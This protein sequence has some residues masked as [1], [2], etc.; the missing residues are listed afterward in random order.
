MKKIVNN[1]INIIFNINKLYVVMNF[2]PVKKYANA[3]L[4]KLQIIK[5]NKGKAGVYCWRNL[6][7]GK[8]Y[9]GC[10]VNLGKRF[11]EYYSIKY[12][13]SGLERSNSLIYRAIL[14]YGYS[15]FSLEII[16]YCEPADAKSREQYY[17]DTLDPDYNLSK[18]A[19]SRLGC[20][21]TEETKAK[22]SLAL[23]G[24]KFS[25]VTKAKMSLA[26][27]G[28]SSA[29]G[30]THSD[31]TKAKMSLA[32]IDSMVPIEVFDLETQIKTIYPSMSATAKALNVHYGSLKNYFSKNTLKPFKKR[33]II[34]K[35]ESK[36]E[37]EENVNT[38]SLTQN[39]TSKTE[40]EENVN[41]SS[42][43]KN[44]TSNI[45]N[46]IQKRTFQRK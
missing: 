27:L 5:D 13:E 15:N 12:L 30:C 42:W 6:K 23:K 39:L 22:M 25:D 35:L 33:Y 10:G 26:A 45:S 36:T 29:K 43:T 20:N 2:K 17:L 24:R 1:C 40:K 7:N 28:N 16:E 38:S 31:E 8:I 32:K 19:G 37:I 18:T 34:K 3:D 21:H 11:K 46:H 41:T 9:I 4:E 44:L 14:K